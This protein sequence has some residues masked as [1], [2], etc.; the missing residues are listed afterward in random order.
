MAVW[1]IFS[2]LF[3]EIKIAK[4]LKNV[5]KYKI[6]EINDSNSDYYKKHHFPNSISLSKLNIEKIIKLV[7]PKDYVVINAEKHDGFKY[8]N[9]L[10]EMG[11]RKIF[12]LNWKK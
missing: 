1:F 3:K 8:Y 10:K 4:I 6:I 12:I 7:L 9:I 2:K 5:N 11:Y